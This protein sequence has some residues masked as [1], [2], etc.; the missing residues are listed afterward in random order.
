MKLPSIRQNIAALGGLQ[1]ANYIIPFL[2]IPFLTRTVGLDAWGKIALAQFILQFFVILTDYGFSWSAVRQIASK[3]NDKHAI[4]VIFGETWAAQWLLFCLSCVI[5][6]L[7]VCGVPSLRSDWPLYIAGFGV[8]LG[9]VLFPLWLMQG[10]EMLREVAVIQ[11]ISKIALLLPLFVLV[12]SSD[13]LT[14]AMLIQSSG[15]LLGGI[16]CLYWILSRRVT[17]WHSPKLVDVWVTLKDG[18]AVFASRVWISAYT[19]L[20]P[21]LIGALAG[22]TAVGLYSLADKVRL[23]AT[24]VLNPISQAL[25]PRMSNLYA[26]DHN[27]AGKL[28]RK[29]ILAVAIVAGSTSITLWFAAEWIINLMGGDQFHGAV[30]V[31]RCLAAVPLLVG[32]SNVFG[33]Q[34]MI[35][36]NKTK[37]FN[38]I[39]AAAGVW[40]IVIIFPLATNYGAVGAAITTATAE[41]LVTLLMAI[42]LSRKGFFTSL[43]VQL[44]KS[45]QK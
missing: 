29:S 3:R 1:I 45:K 41:L 40:A 25:F 18:A 37:A 24:Y 36:N 4:A 15:N 32:L 31:L 38:F 35:A 30:N 33:V 7:V 16:L 17:S 12:K 14:L 28:L 2:A 44:D 26:T 43:T 22:T 6:V 27:E 8:V 21:V 9:N 34:V 11:V 42:Y 19:N 20:I 10:L 5:L 13:D 23:A 39:L